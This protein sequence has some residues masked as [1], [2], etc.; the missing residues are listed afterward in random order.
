M[1]E[2]A[3]LLGRPYSLEGVVVP[4]DHRGGSIGFPT[5]NLIPEQEVLPP[6]GVYLSIDRLGDT[7]HPALTNI[8]YRPT[9]GSANRLTVETHLLEISRE[10]YGERLEIF[11]V[12]KCRDE[13]GFASVDALRDQIEK[14][15]TEAQAWFA[16]HP[17]A[18]EVCRPAL[19]TPGGGDEPE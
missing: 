19:P 8:G 14:D 2:A 6:P 3:E 5:A 1:E 15:R 10:L 4:G 12:R 18:L 9:F 16:E 7:V 13:I 17:P 11:L